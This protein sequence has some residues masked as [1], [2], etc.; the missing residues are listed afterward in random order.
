M[1]KICILLLA[2]VVSVSIAACG[3]SNDNVTDGDGTMTILPTALPTMDTNIPDPDINTEMPMYTEGT[4]V[5][6]PVIDG[7]GSSGANSK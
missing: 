3:R 4:G 5:T 6:D 2:L 1:K 7:S